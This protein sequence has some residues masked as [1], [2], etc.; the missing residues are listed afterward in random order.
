MSVQEPAFSFGAPGGASGVF[1]WATA[2]PGED[3]VERSSKIR[4][5]I[6]VAA[7]LTGVILTRTR[8]S[9]LPRKLAVL[10]LQRCRRRRT[11]VFCT[12]G[13]SLTTPET[14][15]LAGCGQYSEHRTLLLR[16]GGVRL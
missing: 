3:T 12:R 11:R 14:V 4:N 5:A 9:P 16:W 1:S 10:P 6:E 2:L 8:C 15:D 7:P 13:P